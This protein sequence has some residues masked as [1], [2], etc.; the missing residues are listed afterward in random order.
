MPEYNEEQ[1]ERV[2]QKLAEAGAGPRPTFRIVLPD[3][4][5]VEDVDFYPGN[6]AWGPHYAWFTRILEGRQQPD[7]E[8]WRQVKQ[9]GIDPDEWDPAVGTFRSNGE[10]VFVG[11]GGLI[12]EQPYSGV[13]TDERREQFR[14][15][16]YDGAEENLK[17][18]V[19]RCYD[20]MLLFV[21][22]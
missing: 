20:R 18:T 13:F 7:E 9:L 6:P 19:V 5:D 11:P 3:D 17:D 14:Q 16:A 10:P 4:V 15:A 21:T 12:V 22:P 8:F 2:R 1:I